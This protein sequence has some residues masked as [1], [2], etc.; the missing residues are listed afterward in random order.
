MKAMWS[1]TYGTWKRLK[2]QQIIEE[3]M[4]CANVAVS[5]SLREKGMPALFR[6]HEVISADS[7][8]SLKN[9]LRLIHIPFKVT[10][11]AAANIQKVLNEISERTLSVS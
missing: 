11:N 1:P 6:N 7:L 9:F 8:L 4:L 10:G 2:S 5:R 3:F